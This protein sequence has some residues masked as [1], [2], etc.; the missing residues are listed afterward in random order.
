M[1]YTHAR[2]RA[3]RTARGARFGWRA[4]E[5]ALASGLAAL[6]LLAV[7]RRAMLLLQG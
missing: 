1:L 5:P 3:G 6:Y 7:I 4:L 2:R